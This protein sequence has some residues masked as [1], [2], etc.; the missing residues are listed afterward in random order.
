MRKDNEN[1]RILSRNDS[2]KLPLIDAQAQ[3]A[4]KKEGDRLRDNDS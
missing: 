3:Q 4:R 1:S 2:P